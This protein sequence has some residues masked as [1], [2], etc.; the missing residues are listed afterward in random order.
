M[1]VL[2]QLASL[3]KRL[4]C[5]EDRNAIVEV[6][7]RYGHAL[8]YGDENLWQACWHNEAALFWPRKGW[9]H[10]RDSLLAAFREHSHAPNKYH[11]HVVVDPLLDISGDLAKVESY[12]A[13]LHA[14]PGGPYT[15]SFGRYRDVFVRCDDGDWRFRER[16]LE[17]ESRRN[18]STKGPLEGP[19]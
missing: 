8:D 4:Q 17:V 14:D 3:E 19:L 12:F 5:L 13:L 1:G 10:G 2:E 16:R 11:K 15:Y 7:Y 6:L 18:S 9:I